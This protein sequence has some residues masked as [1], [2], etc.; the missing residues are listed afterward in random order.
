MTLEYALK[1]LKG[2]FLQWTQFPELPVKQEQF[3]HMFLQIV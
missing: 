3:S 1:Q 2:K